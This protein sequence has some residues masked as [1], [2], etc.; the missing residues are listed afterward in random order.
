MIRLA[1]ILAPVDFSEPSKKTV[2]YGASLALKFNAQ[3]LLAHIVPRYHVMDVAFPA[4][5]FELDKQSYERAKDLMGELVPAEYGDKVSVE[6]IIKTGDVRD[7]ILGIV[8]NENVDLVVMGSHGRRPFERMFLGSVTEKLLR[9][10]PVPVL[11]VAHID[12]HKE[13][14][15][16]EPIPLKRILFATDLSEGF[17]TSLRFSIRLARSLEC[18][19]TVVHALNVMEQSFEGGEMAVYMPTYR[20]GIRKQF[21]ERLNRAVMVNSDPAVPITS[22][23]TDGV[24]YK[25]VNSVAEET[26][27]DL[28]VINLQS[29]GRLE[30]ALLGSTAERL[31]RTAVVPVLSLPVPMS[32]APHWGVEL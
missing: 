6:K 4:E 18:G 23:F 25:A 1:K 32:Y 9:K 30:R 13:I 11:T 27:A 5:T 17:E 21:E 20:A 31:I 12:P 26:N 8:Q 29:K 16:P 28:I 2:R 22:V 19:L 3:L 10:L 14:H 15:G 24:P 7:E